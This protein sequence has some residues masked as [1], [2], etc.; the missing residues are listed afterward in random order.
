MPTPSSP[1]TCGRLAALALTVCLV[2]AAAAGA[3]AIGTP[4]N[5]LNLK[6]EAS[7]VYIGLE[8]TAQAEFGN[9]AGGLT[10]FASYA[11]NGPALVRLPFPAPFYVDPDGGF[12]PGWSFQGVPPGLYYVV[13]IYGIVATPNVPAQAWRPL[14]VTAGCTT[15]PGLGLVDRQSAGVSSGDVRLF[16]SAVGGCATSYLVEAGTTPG[17]SNVASFEQAGVL[18]AAP[19]VPP[20]NYY[21]RVRGKN[22]F[23][24]GP[25]SAVLPVSVPDCVAEGPDE[26]DNLKATVVGPVVTLTW[27]APVTPPGRPITYYELARLDGVPAGQPPP[28]ILIPSAVTSFSAT[29]PPGTYT[30][31]LFAGNACGTGTTDALRF[32]VP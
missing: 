19:A 2:N 14:P 15:A 11:P 22:Q 29:V 17:G 3:Q 5:G 25:Y 7:D 21:V 24:V 9:T 8:S 31:S 26:I 4:V 12:P 18:L 10:L 1:T 27:T 20:G 13:M 6:S 16:M 32:T 23:G 28:R 30:I